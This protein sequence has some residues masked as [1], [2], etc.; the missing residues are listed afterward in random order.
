VDEKNQKTQREVPDGVVLNHRDL[1]RLNG[2]R[3]L[4]LFSTGVLLSKTNRFGNKI[5]V[6][7]AWRVSA[8]CPRLGYQ[9][10]GV[11][12]KSIKNSSIVLRIERV[13]VMSKREEKKSA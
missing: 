8:L 12:L 3:Y 13:Y 10:L 7:L 2:S 1:N 4:V 9:R 5:Q 11:F 6:L